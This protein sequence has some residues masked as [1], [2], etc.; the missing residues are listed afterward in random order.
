MDLL[1]VFA[2]IL[3]LC[4]FFALPIYFL[5]KLRIHKSLFAGIDAVLLLCSFLFFLHAHPGT[6]PGWLMQTVAVVMMIYV[7]MHLRSMV[8]PDEKEEDGEAEF[9]GTEA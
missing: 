8:R 3:A 9:P 5:G 6:T 2:F 7:Y 4:L 1:K